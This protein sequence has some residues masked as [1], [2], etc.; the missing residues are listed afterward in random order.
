MADHWHAA[1]TAADGLTVALKDYH[2]AQDE[3]VEAGT[4]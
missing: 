1:G 2:H 4:G 3:L